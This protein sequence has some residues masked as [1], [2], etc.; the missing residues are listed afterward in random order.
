M[1]HR[2]ASMGVGLGLMAVAVLLHAYPLD[3]DDSGIRRL[4]GQRILQQGTSHAKLPAG[5]LLS[6]NDISLH[7]EGRPDWDLEPASRDRELQAA[8]E[9]VFKGR[10]PS[11]G[12][13]VVDF[14]DPADIHW[15]GGR[16]ERRQTPGSVGKVLCMTAL[17]DGLRRAFPDITV[18]KRVLREHWV[19]AGDWV[20]S[21]VHKVPR[22]DATTGTMS[23]GVI[24]PGDRFTLGEWLD[25]RISASANAAG[26]L[27]GSHVGRYPHRL[28]MVPVRPA[29]TLLCCAPITTGLHTV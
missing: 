3:G 28:S 29:V 13:L 15:A 2:I 10:G 4:Q 19:D 21:D 16:E 23:Y 8:L 25:H 26:L 6:V 24:H 9:A 7:L 14:T 17:F 11:Y 1:N 27:N 5:T 20:I 22:F 12:V 18:R